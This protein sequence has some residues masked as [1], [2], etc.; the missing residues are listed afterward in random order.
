[1]DA[2]ILAVQEMPLAARLAIE[3]AHIVLA[4]GAYLAGSRWVGRM[5]GYEL[6]RALTLLPVLTRRSDMAIMAVAGI[7]MNVLVAFLWTLV[8]VGAGWLA[9]GTADAP[10]GAV[11][12]VSA[13]AGIGL[14]INSALVVL[15]LLPIPPMALGL[16]VISRLA[17]RWR[18]VATA[19]GALVLAVLSATVVNSVTLVPLALVDLLR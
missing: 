1:M 3:G 9:V 14:G 6:P 17:R 16:L 2:A 4:V 8:V 5:M 12:L 7:L 19:L 15:N 11:D 13:I 10:G 18:I